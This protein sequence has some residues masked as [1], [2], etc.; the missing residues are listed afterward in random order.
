[1]RTLAQ[2]PHPLM[3]ITVSSWNDK[4]QLRFELDRFEQVF[5]IGHNEV[6]GLE[7]VQTMGTALAESALLRFVS[8][9]DSHQ[10]L[11]TSSK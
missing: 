5:K 10:N 1:M 11:N 4:Y 3:R 7:E 9:R 8:M 6:S 2:I